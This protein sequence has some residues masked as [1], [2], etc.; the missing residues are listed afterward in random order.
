[1]AEMELQQRRQRL[2]KGVKALVGSVP[3][4]IASPGMLIAAATL[5]VVLERSRDRLAMSL[6]QTISAISKAASV[7]GR[8]EQRQRGAGVPWT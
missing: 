5:G 7:I 2:I 4:R 8:W 1:M 3:A 6:M